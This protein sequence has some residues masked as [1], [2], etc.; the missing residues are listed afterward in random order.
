MESIDAG[1]VERGSPRRAG[2]GEEAGGE[3]DDT[4]SS[5]KRLSVMMVW[6]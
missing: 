4:S 5:D 3:V 2:D 6:M 1:W